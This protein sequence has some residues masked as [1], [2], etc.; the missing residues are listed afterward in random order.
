MRM[1]SSRSCLARDLARRVHH[2]ILGLLVHREE[3]DLADVGLVGE[4][5]DDPVDARRRAAVRRRADT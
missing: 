4:Q 1:W 5:H 3:H 2:Q